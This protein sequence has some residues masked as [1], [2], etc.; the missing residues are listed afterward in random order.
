MT[1]KK[2]IVTAALSLL[3][4]GTALISCADNGN[5]NPA[6][7]TGGTRAEGTAAE[8]AYTANVPKNLNYNDASFNICVYGENKVVWGDV[9]FSSTV[10][11]GD[12]IND[13]TLRRT[14]KVEEDLHIKIN[15][16]P[17]EGIC[18]QLESVRKSIATQESAYDIAFL[19]IR[20]A[21]SGAQE[22]Y[23]VD[24]KTVSDM[25][26]DAA[27]W[28]Q[29]SI[30]DLSIDNRLYM[31][32]G[33]I[34]VMYKKSIGVML[35]NKDLARDYNIG[36]PYEMVENKEWTI[37][38]F[39]SLCRM[40]HKDVNNDGK[41]TKDDLYGFL[42]YADI[43]SLGIIGGGST[44]AEKDENDLPTI[45][46]YND[47]TVDILSKYLELFNDEQV[48]YDDNNED[49]LKPMFM[50]GNALFDFNEFHAV[51]QLRS[52]DTDFG[53]LPIPLY[54]ETQEDY[55]H[56]INPHVGAVMVIPSDNLDL[57]KTAYVIDSLGAASKNILTPAYYEKYLKGK[58]TR[59]DESQDIIDLV[60]RT[61]R[62][63]MGYMYD[64]GGLSD[65][66]L[67]LATKKSP[68]VSSEYNRIAKK[69]NTAMNKMIS[70][71]QKIS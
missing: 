2:R 10:E 38:R 12:E 63:D 5:K 35:F 51:E 4:C 24:L 45:T 41:Y 19:N 33:D 50:S 42:W 69:A 21:G 36:N 52:M 39:I 54:N 59:D 29:H 13:G 27:W 60:L 62:Y 6:K 67:G 55:Y 26:L 16:I 17:G 8:T 20:A 3:L 31:I 56:S 14:R 28:D 15:A 32:T 43:A 57:Q 64:W 18:G 40:C 49:V 22:G 53:I 37:D 65:L 11:N 44:F 7:E 9:D 70:K 48:S 34:S 47:R 30:T 25:E 58:G 71:I 61:V 1:T 66:P 46:F 23:L 68:N